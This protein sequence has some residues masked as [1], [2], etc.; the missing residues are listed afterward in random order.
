MILTF[1]YHIFELMDF[2]CVFVVWAPQIASR[3]VTYPSCPADL[4]LIFF[5]P[6]HQ[7]LKAPPGKEGRCGGGFWHVSAVV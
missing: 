6:S 5:P 1:L 4:S 7:M 2:G 3:V